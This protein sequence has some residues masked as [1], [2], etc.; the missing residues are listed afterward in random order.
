MPLL[1]AACLPA[2]QSPTTEE[3]G[4]A[5][6][7]FQAVPKPTWWDL[8]AMGGVTLPWPPAFSSVKK[9]L[10][11]LWWLLHNLLP[12]LHARMGKAYTE[13]TFLLSFFPHP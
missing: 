9:Y 11:V 5:W 1:P 4:E 6:P 10:P 8:G 2:R 7:F 13:G 3:C 12:H